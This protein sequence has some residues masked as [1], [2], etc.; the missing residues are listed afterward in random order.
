MRVA[1]LAAV[2]SCRSA[3][4]VSHAVP[5]VVG[6]RDRQHR[7]REPQVQV[8]A[9]LRSSRQTFSDNTSGGCGNCSG[10]RKPLRDLCQCHAAHEHA[11]LPVFERRVVGL[12]T[13]SLIGLMSRRPRSGRECASPTRAPRGSSSVAQAG[14]PRPRS[15]DRARSSA[16]RRSAPTTATPAGDGPSARARPGASR[17]RQ[18]TA[19][20]AAGLVRRSPLRRRPDTFGPATA[21]RREDPAVGDPVVHHGADRDRNHLR[22]QW[23]HT[24]GQHQDRA[25]RRRRA[26]CLLQPH[27]RG[28]ASTGHERIACAIAPGPAA[29]PRVVGHDCGFDCEQRV[30]APEA[31]DLLRAATLPPSSGRRARRR[32]QR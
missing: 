31:A 28:A 15:V 19:T 32:R 20:T 2:Q 13:C 10:C 3:F 16:G 21:S 5:G 7:P 30:P 12:D 29:V 27:A 9:P 8:V 18:A 6:G 11:A 23:R 4:F 26:T 25:G 17:R 14:T 24:S 22:D 1:R